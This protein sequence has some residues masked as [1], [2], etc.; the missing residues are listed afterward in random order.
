MSDVTYKIRVNRPC[1]LFID[2][3]EMMILEESQLTK[4]NLPEG[5]YL[6]KV[7]AIDNSAIYDE[8][9]IV[10]SGAS[11]LD[12]I[13]LDTT[14]LEDAK[15]DALPN[16][17][18]KVGDL[19]FMPSR[20]KFSVEIAHDEEYKYNHKDIHIPEQIVYAGY[21]Y[22]ITSIGESA[23]N[24]CSSLTS[25]IYNAHC[26]A[27]MPT[28]YSGAYTIPE[29]IKQISDYAFRGCKA[30]TSI[31]IPDSVMSIGNYAFSDCKT[32]VTVTIGNSVMSIGENAFA[33][34]NA[35]TSVIIPNSVTRIGD[36]AFYSCY[37]L[38][39]VTIGNSVTSIG[40][41]AF[42]EC[43][44]LTFVT[45]PNSVTSIG[46]YAFYQCSCLKS[47]TIGDRW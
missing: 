23:F 45:I 30:L 8:T 38:T 25:P 6:R 12:I 37:C 43:Y 41:A 15:R 42:S 5:E 27:Y 17:I 22:P 35:L 34:C 40:S 3:E 20:D 29:G 44:G 24:G 31:I 26:F 1:R 14:E 32:L 36:G 21:I 28:S 46:S 2:D 39:S 9:A 47:V 18:F 19:Y 4:I 13:M 11:K 16:E 10:L 7:V 33:N